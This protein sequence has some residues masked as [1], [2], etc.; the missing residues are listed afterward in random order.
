[1]QPCIELIDELGGLLLDVQCRCAPITRLTG[2]RQVGQ[3]ALEQQF[4][5]RMNDLCVDF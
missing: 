4:L 1:V 3:P 2:G 5:L